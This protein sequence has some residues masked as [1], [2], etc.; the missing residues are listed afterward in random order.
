MRLTL[1][2]FIAILFTGLSLS[3]KAHAQS[4]PAGMTY[5]GRLTDASNSPVPDGSGYEIEVRLWSASTGG[6]LLWGT[7]YTGVP[8]KSGAFNLILGSGGTPIS[9]A[10]TTDLKSTFSTVPIYIGITMTKRITGNFFK[11]KPFFIQ[12]N[13]FILLKG[14]VARDFGLPK[15]GEFL[16]KKIPSSC[17]LLSLNYYL[18]DVVI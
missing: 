2:L 15:V 14:T 13:K 3:P 1:Q 17:F 4:V 11:Q 9:G 8:L 16:P 10:T 12:H 5:Q 18:D 6:T 7:R